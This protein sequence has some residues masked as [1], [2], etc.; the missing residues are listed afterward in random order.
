MQ[1][2]L[3]TSVDTRFM[4]RHEC[5]KRMGPRRSPIH[6]GW[7]CSGMYLSCL[8]LIISV[9]AMD[10]GVVVPQQPHIGHRQA[11]PHARDIFFMDSF[12]RISPPP[13]HTSPTMES[14]PE[15]GQYKAPTIALHAGGHVLIPDMHHTLHTHWPM[16]KSLILEKWSSHRFAWYNCPQQACTTKHPRASTF[17][18]AWQQPPAIEYFL[19]IQNNPGE[20]GGRNVSV[21]FCLNAD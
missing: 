7:M 20:S 10:G 9:V 4:F 21:F 11:S 16:I 17:P 14:E 3:V 19:Q 6:H 8:V 18:C 5:Q 12:S 13:R 15:V 2:R 1:E